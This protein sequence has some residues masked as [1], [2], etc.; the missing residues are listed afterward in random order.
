M[1]SSTYLR[2]MQIGC[3]RRSTSALLAAGMSPITMALTGARLP[4]NRKT[5]PRPTNT[6]TTNPNAA[7]PAGTPEADLV[8]CFKAAWRFVA[9]PIGWPAR[10]RCGRRRRPT[11]GRR[12]CSSIFSRAVGRRRSIL[13]CTG[14]QGASADD[15]QGAWRRSIK[16]LMAHSGMSRDELISVSV[17]I[18]QS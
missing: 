13:G 4:G 3:M 18:C 5:E 8:V 16:T 17:S 2:R 7:I 11:G 9:R 14:R 1:D 15:C 6:G 12:I 10:W